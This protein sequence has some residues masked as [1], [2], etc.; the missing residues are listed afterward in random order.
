MSTVDP[1]QDK[2]R[3]NSETGQMEV[4]MGGPTHN[5][6]VAP[7]P[8]P[9]DN[10]Q[11]EPK[12]PWEMD[13]NFSKDWQSDAVPMPEVDWQSNVVQMPGIGEL[14][15]SSFPSGA[16]L[17]GRV[18]RSATDQFRF[19]GSDMFQGNPAGRA[20]GV[21]KW[22][23]PD[24]GVAGT[25]THSDAFI[26]TPGR[27]LS[28]TGSISQAPRPKNLRVSR[29]VLGQP[30]FSG[31][32]KVSGV[33]PYSAGKVASEAVKSAAKSGPG[34]KFLQKYLGRLVQGLGTGLAVMDV[35]S[36]LKEG[37]VAGAGLGAISGVPGPI[38]WLGAGSQFIYDVAR[39]SDVLGRT[40]RFLAGL[41]RRIIPSI[42]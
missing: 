2:R 3:W 25:Y 22:W 35:G 20:P 30:Q 23:T 21:S 13:P 34:R 16:Q 40:G 37:D 31:L 42:L 11:P 8:Q 39:D 32:T 19:G 24:P 26:G 27:G 7:C 9:P 14:D 5:C 1:Y 18:L 10:W 4:N 17:P 28:P 33:V 15:T 29:S 41:G 6:Y 36:R 38:G 12:K